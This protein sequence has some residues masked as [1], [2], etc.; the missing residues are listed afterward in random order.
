M[1]DLKIYYVTGY[2][3]YGAYRQKRTIKVLAENPKQA[4]DKASPFLDT[5]G[6]VRR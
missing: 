1:T 4:R 5:R 3:G 2:E 6:T